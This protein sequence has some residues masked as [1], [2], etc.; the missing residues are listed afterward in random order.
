EATAQYT[1]TFAG[2]TPEVTEV[3]GDAVYTATYDSTVN[4]YT[5][6]FEDEDGSKLSSDLY[7]YGS[8]VAVPENPTKE[9]T[10]EFTYTF[11]GW[12]PKVATVTGDATYKAT[13]NASVNSYTIT[14]KDEDG[15]LIDTASYEY[16][17]TVVEPK[18]PTKEATAQYTYTFAGWSPSVTTVTGDATYKATYKAS[19]NSYTIT[20]EDEDGSE[21][22]SD[23]YAYG[24]T[25]VEPQAPTKEATAQYT[26]TFAG[27]SPKVT[28]VTGDAV[29][30]ATYTETVNNYTITFEDEDGRLIDTASYEYGATV[31]QPQAPT[32]AATAQYTYTFAGWS[33][34]VTE[35]TGDAVYKATYTETVNSYTITFEDEDGRLIDTASY[36]YGATVVEPKAPTKEATA[37]FTYTFAGWNPEVTEVTGDAVYK[38]TYTETVNNYTI[39]FED[40]DGRL[41][42]TASYEYGATVVQPKA[43]TKEATA[44]YSYTFVGWSPE[45]AT[46][47]GDAVYKATYTASVN[48]YTITFEDEDG[49]ELSSA[50][51]AYGSEVTVPENPTKEATAEFT[52]AFAGWSPKVA[53]VTGDAVYTAT[54]DSTVNEYT[55]RFEDEDGSEILK[56]TYAYG[57][58]VAVPENPTKTAT[59][60]FT[61]TFAGWSP[62]VTEVTGDATYKATYTEVAKEVTT[63]PAPAPATPAPATPVEPT[64]VEPTPVVPTPPASVGPVQEPVQEPMDEVIIEDEEIPLTSSDDESDEVIIEE[65]E[66]PLAVVTVDSGAWA[67]LN[68]ILTILTASISLILL[69]GYFINRKTQEDDE[70][71]DD[72]D[73]E[74][75]RK[76]N[77]GLIRVLSI[78]PAVVAIAV[79]ILTENMT[80]PMVMIDKWTTTMLLIT[81]TQMVVAILSVKKD[82]VED[83]NDEAYI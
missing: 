66:V 10:A 41:I 67:L 11:A 7:A 78:L 70:E 6:R 20:F 68:L 61:Y 56:S 2:W 50:T 51:Y 22:S 63:P 62:E 17:A 59:A 64:P 1:Y 69:I 74:K 52:Y 60:E 37:E 39:T 48:S 42:D 30:K 3:T 14:F 19:V 35:V 21:I 57:S 25:V 34:S 33:P 9:A 75:N 32:K 27:W 45:V 53:T 80:N 40:E 79:F 71:Y 82:K 31:V 13:Y 8:E 72:E 4:E 15:R 54:Y 46:V 73:S 55:V 47:T 65:A 81:L 5:V 23:S 28:T 58:D 12:S 36:E 49:T 76:K 18:A 77:R 43:P 24:A 26:Y 44:Q 29:Y 83:K 38:A 16:G